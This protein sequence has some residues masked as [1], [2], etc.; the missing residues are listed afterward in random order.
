MKLNNLTGKRFGRLLVIKRVENSKH[1]ETQWLCK[2]NC[3][4]ETIVNYGKLAYKRTTSCGCYA[5]ELFVNNVSKHNLRK[6]RLYNI[7]A[8]MKQRCF[9][10]NS[11]AYNRYGER[12]I[13]ICNEWKNDFKKFYD[14][15]MKNGYKDN[16][17]IDRINN[18]GNYE[19]ENCRWT[20]NK[21]Q[22]NNRNN[23]VILEYNNEK[24]NLK[25]WCEIMNITENAL[26]H[27]LERGWDVQKA[28][29]TPQRNKQT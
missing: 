28:L 5:K 14:W 23:N 25:Q 18:N 4:N 22:S 11:K 1:N 20:D 27:R 26:K 19:P 2:C 29:T 6:T 16:L 15:S 10:K 9:N 24:H 3:G 17:T 13:T 21:T 7:W 8:G 12:G